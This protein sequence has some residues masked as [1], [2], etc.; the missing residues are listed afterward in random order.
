[1]PHNNG[2][3]I[4]DLGVLIKDQSGRI[5]GSDESRTSPQIYS[6][7][8]ILTDAELINLTQSKYRVYRN[9]RYDPTIA[10]ARQLVTSP[11]VVAGWS[12]EAKENAPPG[13]VD[14]IRK[15]LEPHRVRLVKQAIEGYIDFG[16][17][18]F[19]TIYTVNQDLQHVI[20]RFKNLLPEWT[21]ILVDP[22]DGDYVGMRQYNTHSGKEVDLSVNETLLCTFDVEGT[23]WY[24]IALMENARDP[25]C[26]WNTVE[27]AAHR[28]DKKIAGSHWVVQYPVGSSP[29]NGEQEVSNE[30]IAKEVLDSLEA[31]GK[32][33]VPSNLKQFLPDQDEFT[34]S[35]SG[36]KIELISDKGATSA[37]FTLRQKYLDSLKVRGF[38]LP[39]R[40]ILEGQFGTKA[41]SEAQADF[42]IVNIEQRHLLI[43]QAVNEQTVS[44]LM[45]LNYGEMFQQSVFVKP[46]PI[47]EEKRSWMRRIYERFISDQSVVAQEMESVDWGAL[48]EELDIPSQTVDDSNIGPALTDLLRP[49]L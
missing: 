20:T 46:I 27:T 39:E 3:G 36:W 4:D 21:I 12:Y 25:W 2:Y 43:T 23:Y 26:S 17:A 45:M 24:G 15:T 1:M 47:G 37:A 31:S 41:E 5:R 18:G 14:F 10:F 8:G 35:D 7:P 28:Y 11:I 33:A 48:R 44:R 30:V 38:G 9:M 49:T 6:Q 42:A 16:W 32:I 22:Q 29:H 13:A 19:E 40:A 34:E